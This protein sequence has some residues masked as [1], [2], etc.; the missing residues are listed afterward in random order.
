MSLL[1]W[2]SE[3]LTAD[4]LHSSA[5][6]QNIESLKACV[7]SLALAQLLSLARGFRGRVHDANGAL[8]SPTCPVVSRRDNAPKYSKLRY[9]RDRPGPPTLSAQESTRGKHAERGPTPHAL[10][11][12]RRRPKKLKPTRLSWLATPSSPSSSRRA[13]RGASRHSKVGNQFTRVLETSCHDARRSIGH[14]AGLGDISSY[15]GRIRPRRL[16]LAHKGTCTRASCSRW[17][18]RS[19]SPRPVMVRSPRRTEASSSSS[20]EP[21]PSLATAWARRLAPVRDAGRPVALRAAITRDAVVRR[22]RPA[23]LVR[24]LLRPIG[25]HRVPTLAQDDAGRRQRPARPDHRAPHHGLRRRRGPIIFG[26]GHLAQVAP[27]LDGAK[28]KYG[29]TRHPRLSSGHVGEPYLCDR[30]SSSTGTSSSTTHPAR[31]HHVF[32]RGVP[33]GAAE[34]QGR[35]GSYATH[36]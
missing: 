29:S 33:H 28:D 7:S 11:G 8:A 18:V 32:G 25:A 5:R 30:S 22:G 31:L 12:G 13:W 4:T 34:G 24:P 9:P 27:R 23:P 36:N 6:P 15:L 14:T 35:L 21:S 16:R 2:A 19:R 3:G 1:L 26:D 10:A 20:T 17:T